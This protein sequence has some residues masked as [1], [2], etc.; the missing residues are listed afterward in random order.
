MKEDLSLFTGRDILNVDPF[1]RSDSTSIVPLRASTMPL[2]KGSPNLRVIYA[3]RGN[4]TLK[5]E[6][7]PGSLSTQISPP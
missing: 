5:T 1:P 4:F 2:T 3:L 6:P 7:L